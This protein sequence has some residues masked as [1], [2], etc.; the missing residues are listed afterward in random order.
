MTSLEYAQI[1]LYIALLV[2]AT[3]VLGGYMHRVFDGRRTLLSPVLGPVE[4]AI[5][6]LSGIQPDVEQ[7]WQQ[8]AIALLVFNV[9]GFII[10]LGILLLQGVLPLNPERAG[11]VNPLLAFNI[12]TSFMTN[13]NWQS[14]AGETTLSL[15]SQMAGLGVQNFLSAAT[16]IAVV[17]GL[18][19]GLA[20]KSAKTVGNFQADQVRAILY[21]LLP[22]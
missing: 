12:A 10:L 2:A 11:G 5:Y 1:G 14:Y 18:T 16:G 22:L 17:L 15:F 13:T 9:L 6:R 4:R 20:R 19:R 21:M 3:P 8:F 7:R